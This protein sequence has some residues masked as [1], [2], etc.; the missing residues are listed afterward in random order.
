M[1]KTKVAVYCR[2]ATKEQLAV[3]CQKSQLQNY[4]NSHPGWCAGPVYSDFAPASQL[5]EGSDL[6][7]MLEDAAKSSFQRVA[8]LSV[9]R[10]ARNTVR[11]FQLVDTFKDSG[12]A[13]DF[14]KEGISTDDIPW[15]G[16]I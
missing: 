12:V 3:D 14:L 13:V 16:V 4:I 2:V 1:K 7:R 10:L 6:A 5:A 11:L 9:S 15:L 8:V